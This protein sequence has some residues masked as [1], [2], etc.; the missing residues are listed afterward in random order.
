MEHIQNKVDKKKMHPH[1]FS[2]WIGIASIIMMFGGLTSGFIV[3]KPQGD[4][5]SYDLPWAFYASTV[6]VVLSSLTMHLAVKKF[7][8]GNQSAH[9]SLIAT[10]LI[11]GIAFTVLQYIGFKDMLSSMTWMNNISFQF[12]TLIVLVHALHIL[13]GIVT[14][15]IFF[16]RTFSKKFA[17]FTPDGLETAAIYWHF[18][19]VLW[20]YLFIFFLVSL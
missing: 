10:T 1:K 16:F 8:Q 6:C 15:L 20:I 2:L 9:K 19:D 13:G 3:R 12:V 17:S 7:K 14:I 11:L 5:I 18:V 4:W